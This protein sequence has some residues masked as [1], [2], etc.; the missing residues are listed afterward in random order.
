MSQL[1]ARRAAI[2]VTSLHSGGCSACA[3]SLAALEAPRYA[4]RLAALGVTL[5]RVPRH[6]DIVLLCGALTEQA[7]A[8]IEGLIAGTPRPRALVAVGDCAVNGCV[9]ASSPRLSIPLA[10]ALNVNVEIGG[11]PPAPKV[12]I[13]AII[14]ARRLLIAEATI[15]EGEPVAIGVSPA[16]SAAPD[17]AAR[18]ASLIES[19]REGWDDDEDADEDAGA[20][21]AGGVSDDTL[22]TNDAAADAPAMREHEQAPE[23]SHGATRPSR[24]Q[25]EEKH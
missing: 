15:P 11:C 16:S 25:P 8:S 1:D 23:T 20:D 17:R 2:A 13:E 19:A 3:E 21:D 10:Q 4:K 18:L 12:I 24:R 6:A 9:F 5:T 22:D 14:E 7:R